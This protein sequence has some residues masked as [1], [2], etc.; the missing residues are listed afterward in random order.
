MCSLEESLREPCTVGRCRARNHTKYQGS[1]EFKQQSFHAN[2]T[3]LVRLLCNQIQLNKLRGVESNSTSPKSSVSCLLSSTSRASTWHFFIETKTASSLLN[4]Q[5][6]LKKQS[7][8]N[9]KQS[10]RNRGRSRSL[11]QLWLR[12]CRVIISLKRL[13]PSHRAS[14]R[15]TVQKCRTKTWSAS[16]ESKFLLVKPND[17][18]CLILHKEWVSQR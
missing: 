18:V 12:W 1:L 7:S 11:R 3:N 17:L 14:T 5:N 4:L 15:K 8:Q 6:L 10:L 9:I 2:L 16:K 13:I